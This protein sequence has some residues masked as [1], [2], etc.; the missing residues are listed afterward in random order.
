MTEATKRACLI[1]V[2]ATAGMVS[3]ARARLEAEGYAVC[4]VLA[5]I[6]TATAAS[7]NDIDA[8]PS[9]VRECV[10]TADLCV[11]LLPQDVANDGGIPAGGSLAST[12]GKPFIGI[13]QGEREAAPDPFEQDAAGI[14]HDC[15]ETLAKAIRGDRSFRNP[16]G[17]VRERSI[18]H[19]KCQ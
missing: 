8:L 2:S 17:T 13:V 18:R 11:F 1:Y 10:E 3:P 4:E 12:L 15:D 5:D 9:A 14:V 7:V 6:D 16:D 19:L